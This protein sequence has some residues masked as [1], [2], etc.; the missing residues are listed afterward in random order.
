M[1]ATTPIA[2]VTGANRGLGL[3]I[4]RQ[5]AARSMHVVMT[6]RSVE[7]ADAAVAQVRAQ[8]GDAS[9]FV[10]DVRDEDAGT[11]LA[12][13]LRERF[14]RVDV[15][16]NNAGVSLD[17]H[18]PGLRVDLALVRQT[19]EVNVYGALRL[20]QALIPAMVA[21]GYG[22]VVNLSSELGAL[23]EIDA[24]RLAYRMSKASLNVVTRVL[25]AE[26]EGTGVLVNSMCPGWVSTEM[27]GTRAPRS[28]EQ[29][30]DTAVWLATLPDDG[31]N[32][33]FFQDRRPHAW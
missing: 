30:A 27:G 14:G 33:G 20:C 13:H 11:R 5:L 15:L 2:V 28:V 25:A 1:T 22:R 12:T 8:G 4:A 9:A 21:R 16:I 7:L 6:A 32:G 10:I 26:I 24:L 18:E 31:P 29:G 3:E 17:R 23:N 19:M